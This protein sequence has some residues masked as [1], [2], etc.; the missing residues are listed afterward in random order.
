[1]PMKKQGFTLTEVLVSMVVFATLMVVLISAFLGIAQMKESSRNLTQA[2]SDLRTVS[3]AM[4]DASAAS[5]AAVTGTNWTAWASANGLV[6]LDNEAVTV[7]Y[8]NPAADPL[9]VTA[10]VDW[11]ERLR[12]RSAAVNTLLTKR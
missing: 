4:R 1:M 6:S 11:Q 5:L 3:E 12:A 7:T 10:R 2:M 8:A 9:D